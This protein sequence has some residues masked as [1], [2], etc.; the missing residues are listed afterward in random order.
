MND[1]SGIGKQKNEKYRITTMGKWQQIQA[2]RNN[3]N[4]KRNTI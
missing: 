2:Q 1:G 3:N 4:D